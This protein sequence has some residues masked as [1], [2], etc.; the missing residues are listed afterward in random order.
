[1]ARPAS[2]QPTDGELAILKV[3]WAEG[4]AELRRIC[5]ERGS[6]PTTVATMLQIMLK[7]GLVTRTSGE[8]GRLWAARVSR[9]AVGAGFLRKVIDSVFDGSARLLVAQLLDGGALS[10]QDCREIRRL[11]A[12]ADRQKKS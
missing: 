11:L 8:R 6:A 10:E 9:A 12:A 5:A 3:L 7:K 1:M 2:A 4:P